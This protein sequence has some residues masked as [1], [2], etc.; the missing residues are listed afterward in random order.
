MQK[1]SSV[2]LDIESTSGIPAK[3]GQYKVS[4]TKKKNK[5]IVQYVTE[6]KTDDFYPYVIIHNKNKLPSIHEFL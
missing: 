3:N 6:T 1:G 2:W 5:N 4:N